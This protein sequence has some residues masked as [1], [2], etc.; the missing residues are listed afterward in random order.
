VQHGPRR[1]DGAEESKWR[2][3]TEEEWKKIME[4]AKAGR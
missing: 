3:I 2:R 4:A 1:W